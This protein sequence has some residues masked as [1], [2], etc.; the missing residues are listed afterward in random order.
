M[1]IQNAPIEMNTDKWKEEWKRALSSYLETKPIATEG[2]LFVT[3]LGG[4]GLVGELLKHATT[5]DVVY[6]KVPSKEKFEW[7]VAIS[8]SGNTW[9]TLEVVE[10]MRTQGTRLLAITSG[11]KLAQIADETIKLPENMMARDAFP[12]IISAGLASIGCKNE[13]IHAIDE[14]DSFQVVEAEDLAEKIKG[15]VPVIYASEWM[16]VA[17][18]RFKQQLNENAKMFAFFSKMPDAFHNDT[19]PFF[20]E[21]KEFIAII[22]GKGYPEKTTALPIPNALMVKVDRGEKI[23]DIVN[24]ICLLDYVSIRLTEIRKVSRNSS[25]RYGK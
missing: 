18:K 15:K 13:L 10:K 5:R 12:Y 4:S 24:A 25:R 22:M 14:I 19:E 2:K 6:S 20:W 1:Q 21:N 16:V 8:Y 7:I 9:E 3:G 17:A 23:R 11:G